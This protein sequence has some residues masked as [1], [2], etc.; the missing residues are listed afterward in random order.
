MN[1]L[2]NKDMKEWYDTYD[3]TN[4]P[5]PGVKCPNRSCDERFVWGWCTDELRN[6]KTGEF[7]PSQGI[8]LSEDSRIQIWRCPK[9]GVVLAIMVDD[10]FGGYVYNHPDWLDEEGK[11]IDWEQDENAYPGD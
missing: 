8:E 9:C 2:P 11:P 7:A 5:P 6:P 3:R 1:N 4:N 10:K